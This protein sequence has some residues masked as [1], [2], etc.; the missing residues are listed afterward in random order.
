MIV[1]FN[2]D[3]LIRVIRQ[4]LKSQCTLFTFMLDYLRSIYSNKY[5]Y[6]SDTYVLSLNVRRAASQSQMRH[7]T[8][9]LHKS[10]FTCLITCN[11]TLKSSREDVRVSRMRP[12]DMTAPKETGDFKSLPRHLRY[13]R[14]DGRTMASSGKPFSVML[15][16]H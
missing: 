5:V 15:E 7:M 8:E 12:S 14:C 9:R 4:V 3:Y 10:T 16:I 1:K 13:L 2:R 6:C 11:P